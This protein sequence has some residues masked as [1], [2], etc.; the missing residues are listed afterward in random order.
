[1]SDVEVMKYAYNRNLITSTST[2]IENEKMKEVNFNMDVEYPW[3]KDIKVSQYIN[4]EIWN[5]YLEVEGR[6]IA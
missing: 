1:M 5:P 6:I 2:S 3:L 4:M